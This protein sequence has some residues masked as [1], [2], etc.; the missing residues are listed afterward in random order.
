LTYAVQ[1]PMMSKS[2]VSGEDANP[3][4]K[5]LTAKTGQTP[6]WNF[7]KYVILPGGKEVS[8]YNSR[9]LPN[10]VAIIDKIKPHLK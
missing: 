6:Q 5:Q 1:F 9:V 8:V 7:Y 2:A 3:F 4:Y 10:S